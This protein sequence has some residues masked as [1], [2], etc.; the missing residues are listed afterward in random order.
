M[1]IVDHEAS[2]LPIQTHHGAKK[3][4]SYFLPSTMMGR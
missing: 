4:I 1:L 3:M 2:A